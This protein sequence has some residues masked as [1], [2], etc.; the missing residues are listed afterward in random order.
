MRKII[1][2]VLAA[3]LLA[4]FGYCLI[5]KPKF[6][7]IKADTY[8]VLRKVI[9]KEQG[10]KPNPPEKKQRRSLERVGEKITYDIRLGRLRLGRARY[11]HLPAVELN[12]RPASHMTF[13][14]KLARFS[15][16]EKIYSDPDTL[17]PIKIERDVY[18]WPVSEKITEEY[19]QKNFTLVIRK[20]KYKSGEE[21]QLVIK[22]D[23][24]IHNAIMLP[25]YL[26]QIDTLGAGWS[27]TANLP[28]QQ[29]EIRLVAVEE[30]IVPAGSFKA[31]H[32]KSAPERFEIW[33]SAD[34]RK[35]PVKIKGSGAL[36]YTFIMR[37]YGL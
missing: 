23:G 26:R 8:A 25:F 33:V 12:G 22:K 27:M 2:I 13:E 35:I 6:S 28:Y 7:R 9:Q 1:Y 32:F 18:V 14:T 19:D 4:A 36:G 21:K 31:Y 34:E 11:N 29:F 15:D 24:P 5:N 10:F 16:L 30:V 17:L 37:E 20:Y 3:S